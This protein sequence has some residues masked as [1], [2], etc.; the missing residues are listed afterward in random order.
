MTT[1]VIIKVGADGGSTGGPLLY[2]ASGDLQGGNIVIHQ[3]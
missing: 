3:K 2:K 1:G